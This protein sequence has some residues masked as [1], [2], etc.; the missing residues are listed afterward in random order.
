[1]IFFLILEDFRAFE[2]LPF[3]KQNSENETEEVNLDMSFNHSTNLILS[4][5]IGTYREAQG[6][7]HSLYPPLSWP[8]FFCGMA[9]N[10]LMALSQFPN[11]YRKKI[12]LCAKTSS[13][14]SSEKSIY[15]FF[16]RDT[17]GH[18]KLIHDL[19]SLIMWLS[20]KNIYGLKI[21]HKSRNQSDG[22][23]LTS[24]MKCY[25]YTSFS[26]IP[27][28]QVVI[29]GGCAGIISPQWNIHVK[30]ALLNKG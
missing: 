13:N 10:S 20:L 28:M 26:L 24:V 18:V 23:L 5:F 9:W 29:S 8:K 2:E 30:R 15:P 11:L 19:I 6:V 1:M 25:A 17:P 12:F 22:V 14:F 27:L 3:F 7:L 16:T 21:R 4:S